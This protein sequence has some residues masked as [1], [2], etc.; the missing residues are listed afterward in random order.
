[1]WQSLK[2][3]IRQQQAFFDE[4]TRSAVAA[5]TAGGGRI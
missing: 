3:E 5:C 4:Q 2:E 1:M